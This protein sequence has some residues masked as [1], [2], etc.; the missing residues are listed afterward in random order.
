[1]SDARD[2]LVRNLRD[3]MGKSSDLS[4]QSHLAAESKVTI[5]TINGL[6]NDTCPEASEPRIDIVEKLA[7]A[8]GF[9][10]WQL[11]HPSLRV[12]LQEAELYAA[13]RRLAKDNKPE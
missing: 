5:G 8:F 10:A 3:L 13:F 1:M 4:A 2:N 12:S 11:L 6:L 7:H 9:D